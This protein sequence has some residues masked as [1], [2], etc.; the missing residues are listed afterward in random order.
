MSIESVQSHLE[1]GKFNELEIVRETAIGLYLNSDAGEILLPRK[2]VPQGACAGSSVRVFVYRDSE[3]RLIAT[4]LMP[5]AV[6]GEVAYLKVVAITRAGAFLDWGIQKDLLVPYSEQSEKM[7]V[8]KKYIVRIFLDER[9]QRIAATAKIRK[10]IEEEGTGLRRGQTVSLLVYRFV[11]TGIKVIID[12]RCFGM[13]YKNEVFDKLHIGDKAEGFV[14]RIRPDRKIDV[15]LGKGGL[16]ET[17]EAKAVILRALKEHSGFLP[18]G[19]NSDP[20]HIREML[21]MSK[22]TFKKAAGGLYKDDM[23]E[24]KENG[25][26]LKR[27]AKAKMVHL[28]KF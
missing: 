2:Y 3:D 9:T 4:T 7:E 23:I 25:I 16:A 22:R 6:V 13:L 12:N 24:I 5:A 21:H 1:I 15:M 18:L 10:F 26:K 19:D 8:G 11:E 14:S 27:M 28:F 20:G 17:D